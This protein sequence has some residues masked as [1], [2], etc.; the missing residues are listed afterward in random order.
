LVCGNKKT[1]QNPTAKLSQ[2]DITKDL[3]DK[4]EAFNPK[5]VWARFVFRNAPFIR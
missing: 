1:Q 2:K 3:V 4:L 5:F